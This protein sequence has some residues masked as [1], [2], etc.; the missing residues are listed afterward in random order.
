M[1]VSILIPGREDR[2][3]RYA[4]AIRRQGGHPRFGEAGADCAGLLLPGG[5]DLDP[6]LYGQPDLGS[7]PGD[8]RQDRL[9]LALARE[10][11]TAGKPVLG[12]CRGLQVV[13]VALG[14]TLVQDLPGHSQQAGADRVHP[15]TV[16]EGSLAA[17][18]WGRRFWVNS[19]HHQAAAKPGAGLRIT[20]LADDGTVEALEGTGRPVWAFQW[21]PERMTPPLL[22]DG[23]PLFAF[24]LEKCREK[25][26]ETP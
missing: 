10:F 14:G 9:E 20:A 26:T 6:A 3:P 25:L 4:A 7:R 21:H 22:P 2:L 19:A 18:L 11:L 15:V 24:F 16:A 5:G 13:N 17:A 12:I 1:S 23:G 8:A